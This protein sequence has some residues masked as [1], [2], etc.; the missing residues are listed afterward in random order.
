MAH[1]PE[2]LRAWITEGRDLDTFVVSFAGDGM[3]LRRPLQFT[4]TASDLQEFVESPVWARSHWVVRVEAAAT[5][6]RAKPGV[7]RI[8]R[9]LKAALGGP[10]G[11]YFSVKLSG[12]AIGTYVDLS[13][14]EAGELHALFVE[15]AKQFELDVLH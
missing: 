11:V 2:Q 4:V 13:D 6:A 5:T 1:P 8:A 10:R 12:G 15:Y 9:R 7:L 3:P 14:R